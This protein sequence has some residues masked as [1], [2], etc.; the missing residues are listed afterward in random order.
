MRNATNDPNASADAAGTGATTDSKGDS[1]PGATATVITTESNRVVEKLMVLAKECG[2]DTHIASAGTSDPGVSPSTIATTSK[3]VRKKTN[4]LNNA[5]E[6]AG[7]SGPGVTHSTITT[8]AKKKVAKRRRSL[9]DATESAGTCGLGDAHSMVTTASKKS[10]TKRPV[11]VPDLNESAIQKA[12]AAVSGPGVVH[13]DPNSGVKKE[14]TNVP[15]AHT[16]A[17]DP[18]ILEDDRARSTDADST[19]VLMYAAPTSEVVEANAASPVTAHPRSTDAGSFSNGIASAPAEDADS[20]SVD[21]DSPIT[22]MPHKVSSSA[23][24][25]KPTAI[26]KQ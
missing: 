13:M 5:A 10:K 19:D 26:L 3:M 4:P 2:S 1:T 17:S 21:V 11:T 24:P 25:G 7:A 18:A 8:A 12:T 23:S 9:A 20:I 15:H 22:T 6:S 16:V 14:E